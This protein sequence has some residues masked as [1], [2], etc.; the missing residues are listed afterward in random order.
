M[1]DPNSGSGY[2]ELFIGPMFSGKTSR[3]IDIYKREEFCSQYPIV[4]NYIGD[5]RYS[6]H[7]THMSSHDSIQIP[8]IRASNLTDVF[9]VSLYILMKS[10]NKNMTE[11]FDNIVLSTPDDKNNLISK[12]IN[13]IKSLVD[14]NHPTFTKTI[15]IN[16]G[17]F[18]PDIFDWVKHMVTHF[19][20]RIY[21]A[22]LDGDFKQQPIGDILKLI[23][24]S[25][26]CTKLTSLCYDCRD[27]TE[28]IFSHRITNETEQIV[29]GSDNYIPLCRSCY[30][31]RQFKTGN[32]QQSLS[33]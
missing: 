6:N 31:K 16:E 3:L 19:N 18:F 10:N 30:Y 28:A 8:C 29:I 14:V 32:T 27:G 22:G 12:K 15:I 4:I 7:E 25:N 1:T 21:I 33:Y 24:Y 26:R 2:L 5:N 13:I 9:D 11:F 20:K 17:Q 23:P